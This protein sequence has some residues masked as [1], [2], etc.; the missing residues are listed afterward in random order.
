MTV[1]NICQH[2]ETTTSR[3]EERISSE[4]PPIRPRH[5]CLISSLEASLYISLAQTGSNTK[6]LARK[7]V[8]SLE[9]LDKGSQVEKAS[10][11]PICCIIMEYKLSPFQHKAEEN[12]EKEKGIERIIFLKLG[13]VISALPGTWAT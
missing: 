11:K 10:T 7:V 4:I 2:P 13:R 5:S 1:A 8:L 3:W 9:R 12:A 6:T